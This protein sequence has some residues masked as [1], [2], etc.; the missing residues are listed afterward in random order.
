MSVFNKR[1]GCF[2]SGILGK[3]TTH[4]GTECPFPDLEEEESP[5]VSH[6]VRKS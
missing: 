6:N 2:T 5:I 1:P 4:F 3:N